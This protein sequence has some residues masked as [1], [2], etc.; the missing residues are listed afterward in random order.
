MTG[1]RMRTPTPLP[2]VADETAAAFR[3]GLSNGMVIGG[4]L[5]LALAVL[6]G[7]LR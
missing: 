2:S 6:A 3:A 4:V 7:W 1:P 5:G